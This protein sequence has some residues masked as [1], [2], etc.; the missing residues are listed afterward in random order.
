MA[1]RLP[2]PGR[3]GFG[4]LLVLGPLLLVGSCDS[5]ERPELLAAWLLLLLLNVDGRPLHNRSATH[6]RAAPVSGEAGS[7]SLCHRCCG[8]V[9]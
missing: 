3:K 9:S 1:L 8:P 6:K 4:L 7:C 5:V 2:Q